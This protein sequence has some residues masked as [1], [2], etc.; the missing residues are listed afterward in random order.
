M[1]QLIRLR[2]GRKI[3]YLL[4]SLALVSTGCTTDFTNSPPTLGVEQVATVPLTVGDTAAAIERRYGGEVAVWEPGAY[5]VLSLKSGLSSQ[6]LTAPTVTVEPNKDVFLAGGEVATMNGRTRIWAG[7][8]ASVWAGGRTRIWAGGLGGLWQ[9]GS[10]TWM[11]ENTPLWRQ[12]G[13]EQGHLL[14]PN[15]GYGV[16][17]AV[18][19]TGAVPCST[20]STIAP[21][22]SNVS[23]AIGP[24]PQWP[25]PGTRNRRLQPITVAAPPFALPIR[26]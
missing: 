24:P 2:R 23:S 18:I 13:L 26:S 10:F 11:P 3:Y 12:I 15:L 25:M 7:G 16:T 8:T 6:A 9:D 17:V 5:A 21:T 19:D 20:Q 14:A 4:A 1:H 22:M